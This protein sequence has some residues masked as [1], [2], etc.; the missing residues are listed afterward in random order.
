MRAIDAAAVA[1][2][3]GLTFSWALNGVA[4]KLANAGYNPVL[5]TLLRSLIGTVC[6]F[7]WCRWRRVP[8]F[9][10]DGTLLAGFAAGILFGGEFVLIYM[11]LDF[12]TVARSALM[13]NTMPFWVLLGAHFLLGERMSAQ[14][15]VGLV[16]AFGGVVL[17]FSDRLSLPDRDA[18]KG[19]LMSLAAGAFW[20]ATTLVIKGSKL[21]KT[22]AEKVL[23]YQLAV[24]AVVTL[25]LLPFA[26]PLVREPSA[27]AVG[28]LLFQA[29]FVVGFTYV[30]WFGIMRRYPAAGLSSFTFLTPAFGVLLGGTLLGEPLSIQIFLALGL[31]AAGLVLVNRVS[32]SQAS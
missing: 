8:L 9:E 2:M 20:A 10:R 12:T 11:G 26:T 21:A 17:V 5:L 19:D 3:I 32:K 25:P 29:I 18:I 28:A 4:A 31:I 14:K 27:L 13:V 22:S 1:I 30:V 7:I 24:S 15:L 23:L 6:V 16:L